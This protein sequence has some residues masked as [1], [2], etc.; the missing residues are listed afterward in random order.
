MCPAPG[1]RWGSASFADSSL[2]RKNNACANFLRV[3]LDTLNEAVL[4]ASEEH[5]LTPEAIE[6]VIQLSER[7]DVQEKKAELDQEQKDIERKLKNLV[8]A[9]ASGST[10]V[11][12]AKKELEARQVAIQAELG[13]MEAIP[14]P[15]DKVVEDRLGEWRRMLRQSTT[16]ARLVIQ[17]VIDGRITFMPRA[18]SRKTIEP[19]EMLSVEEQR[20]L[21]KHGNG[22]DFHAKT[23]FDRLFM[24]IAVPRPRFI[25]VG[26]E[27]TEH[28]TAEDTF[29]AD[30]G[31]LLEK[32]Q[33][34]VKDC[35]IR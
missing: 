32:A 3:G 15:D 9:V 28:I 17:R 30:Y 13:A 21:G 23:R 29:D 26:K 16:Q 35:L 6:H 7:N 22:Y 34:G 18:I 5:V 12:A 14:R 25:T 4:Q 10:T 19:I 20:G 24:G 27:G 33:K 1:L 8:D 31:R 2:H 11:M